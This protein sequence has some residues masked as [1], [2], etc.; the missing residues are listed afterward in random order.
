MLKSLFNRHFRPP[1]RSPRYEAYSV[2][3]SLATRDGESA[4]K[5]DLVVPSVVN[6]AVTVIVVIQYCVLGTNGIVGCC[7]TG[8][9][10]SGP[11]PP[12]TDSDTSIFQSTSTSRTT[13]IT[14]PTLTP[15]PTISSF[16]H[17]TS[18]SLGLSSRTTSSSISAFTGSPTFYTPRSTPTAD[19]GFTNV[20]VAGDDTDITWST[21]DWTTSGSS[22]DVSKQ[23]R[24]TTGV[25]TFTYMASSGSSG[26]SLYLD[27]SYQNTNFEIFLDG[28]QSDVVGIEVD[29]CSFY[30]IGRLPSSKNDINVTIVVTGPLRNGRRQLGSDNFSF[31]FNGFMIGQSTLKKAGAGSQNG[32][33]GM[34]VVSTLAVIFLG[35]MAWCHLANAASP[36]QPTIGRVEG[37]KLIRGLLGR[38]EF[39]DPGYGLCSNGGCC[40]LGG[41]CC[42]QNG[43]CL[44]GSYC[45]LGSN[46]IVGCCPNGELLPRLIL[47]TFLVPRLILSTATFPT[48]SFAGS[49]TFYAPQNTP[50]PD[51]GYV[52]VLIP[53]NDARI[54]WGSSAWTD[55]SSSCDSTRTCRKTQTGQSSF[56]YI[57]SSNASGGV[58]YMD[59][60]FGNANL[61][62]LPELTVLI[63][64]QIANFQSIDVI[65]CD[66]SLI[67]FLPVTSGTVNITVIVDGPSALATN[68]RQD[69]PWSFEFSGFM[70]EQRAATAGTSSSESST[71]TGAFGGG[72]SV[73]AA[74]SNS[75]PF[76]FAVAVAILILASIQYL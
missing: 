64:G 69:S 34:I 23:C 10:C 74:A 22:C 71:A 53:G 31:E 21:N 28:Q 72:S 75:K 25:S 27:I 40:P 45:D 63:N 41:E 60:S 1:K 35:F 56:T 7:P 51:S 54:T 11:A 8:E 48:S 44:E 6:A 67:T 29:T 73:S 16:S 47:P 17:V 32:P 52:N 13:F 66:Y 49:P 59:A 68:K 14:T 4:P 55:S 15:T 18:S 5:L 26:S 50:T 58:I 3:S 36:L 24:K 2:D 43:C 70:I 20:F 39:C 33:T 12:S 46:G 57:A 37:G 42:Q 65:F 30:T 62:M 9:L 38:Q 76:G 61:D 19:A